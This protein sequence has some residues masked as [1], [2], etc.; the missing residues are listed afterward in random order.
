MSYIIRCVFC[1]ANLT[2]A[3]NDKIFSTRADDVFDVFVCLIFYKVDVTDTTV[4]SIVSGTPDTMVVS[5]CRER[6]GHDSSCSHSHWM[7]LILS[8]PY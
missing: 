4:V 6:Y 8:H 2:C 3:P 1:T 7:A 5:S